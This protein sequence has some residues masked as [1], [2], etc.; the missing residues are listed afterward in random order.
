[1]HISRSITVA[2]A[3]TALVGAA[4][5]SA[6]RTQRAPGEHFD[7]AVVLT[8]VKS[9]LAADQI[10]EAHDINVEVNRGVV[11]LN[12]FVDS[13]KEK[14]QATAVASRVEGVKEV[15]NN[16]AVNPGERTAGEVVDDALLTAKVKTALIQNPD[17]KAHQITVKTENG[18]VQL[19]GFV[20]SAGAREAAATVAMS[21]TGVR[22][23][24]N[25]LGIK[26]Y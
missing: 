15:H 12:G 17:T 23:V 6:T 3:A 11:Q 7:D 10:T 13:T 14:S 20:D 2:L 18:V 1:M 26:S 21:V 16:L 8:S 24:D 19:S 4:S 25:E 5:C 9:A 22:G